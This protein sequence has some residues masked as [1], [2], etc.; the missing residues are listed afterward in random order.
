MKKKLNRLLVFLSVKKKGSM[1]SSY[2]HGWL[3][4]AGSRA[5]KAISL[6]FLR[7]TTGEE[8]HSS[9]MMVSVCYNR[10]KEKISMKKGGGRRLAWR[11]L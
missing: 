9:R 6:A 3:G 7:L 8:R 2:V 4:C 10:E 1:G 11:W 5:V